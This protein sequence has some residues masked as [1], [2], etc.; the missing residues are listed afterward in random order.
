MQKAS[1]GPVN[2]TLLDILDTPF[3]ETIC[4]LYSTP[5]IPVDYICI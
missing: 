5:N 2:Q 4:F 1:V 3:F